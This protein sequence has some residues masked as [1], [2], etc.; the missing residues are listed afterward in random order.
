MKEITIKEI[1]Q[2]FRDAKQFCCNKTNTMNSIRGNNKLPVIFQRMWASDKFAS[3]KKQQQ[4]RNTHSSVC[5][6]SSFNHFS[7]S[8]SDALS[9]E[10]PL[11]FAHI[12]NRFSFS[13]SSPGQVE[14]T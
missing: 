2:S 5:F 9:V 8:N 13:L 3:E 1:R 12:E 6:I 14:A 4:K 11:V 7:G 10:H